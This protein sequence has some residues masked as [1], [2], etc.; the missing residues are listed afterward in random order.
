MR[1]SATAEIDVKK[2][3][4]HKEGDR[5]RDDVTVVTGLFDND[6]NYISGS[7]KVVEM[8][9]RDETLQKRVDSGIG[10]RSSF[11]VHPGR[12]MSIRMVVPQFPKVRPLAAQSSLVENSVSE[13]S[14]SP[15]MKILQRFWTGWQHSRR[16]RHGRGV[17]CGAAAILHAR[18]TRHRILLSAQRRVVV[19]V[20]AVAMDKKGK[21]AS[22]LTEKNFK[23]FEDNKERRT[24]SSFSLES[25]GLSPERSKK[26]YITMFFDTSTASQTAE[27]VVRQEGVRFVGW[28]YASPD[29]Y[30]AVVSFTLDGGVR[31]AQNFTTDK[32]L[33]KNALNTVQGLAGANPTS[34]QVGST[35][36]KAGID[37]SKGPATV[38]GQNY[39]SMLASLRSVVD[40]LAAN[41]Q[42]PQSSGVLHRQCEGRGRYRPGSDGN[43][44]GLQQSERC[45]LHSR[46]RTRF[47]VSSEPSSN[48]SSAS[49]AR[50]IR[51]KNHQQ[52]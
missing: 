48:A 43:D 8:Q 18:R 9:L 31:V 40:S 42:G 10:V 51:W 19:L 25:A 11:A 52:Q 46:R 24:I 22:D 47:V 13:V 44:R 27:I 12:Y 2:L 38:T 33:L 6:G 16:Y 45:D 34:A 14:K 28:F 15:V 7:Q 26:H 4:F 29:R 17:S 49:S 1:L 3:A 50:Q 41:G 36:T 21:F 37:A 32:T 35:N 39:R 30:M 20:D 5:N 23:L